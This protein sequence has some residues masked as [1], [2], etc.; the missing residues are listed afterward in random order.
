LAIENLKKHMILALFKY[1][2]MRLFFL[3]FDQISAI[4]NLKKHMILALFKYIE[5]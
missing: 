1:I 5:I 4:E 3:K 2:E